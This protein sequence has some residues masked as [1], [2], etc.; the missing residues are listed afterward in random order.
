[1]FG[2]G[3]SLEPEFTRGP[4][5]VHVTGFHLFEARHSIRFI[6]V[7]YPRS[8]AATRGIAVALSCG[9]GSTTVRWHLCI[10]C[11][12]PLRMGYSPFKIHG[13]MPCTRLVACSAGFRVLHPPL[14]PRH[15]PCAPS[16]LMSANPDAARFLLG[17]RGCRQIGTPW[18]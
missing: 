3:L 4:V 16:C 7:G 14:V 13:S 15:P 11:Q 6:R 9:Y 2:T 18:A 12:L 17:L 1:M 5:S 10:Q 8:L